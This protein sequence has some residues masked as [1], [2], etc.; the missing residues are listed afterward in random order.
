MSKKNRNAKKQQAEARSERMKNLTMVTVI[1]LFLGL[2]IFALVQMFVGSNEEP[3]AAQ[4]SE[5][6]FE[7]EGQPVL[8]DPDAP[9][10]IVEFG[11]FKC[12]ACKQFKDQI[13]PQ[14]KKDY[15]DQGKVAFYFVNNPFIGE[16]SMTAAIAAES[17]YQQDPDSYWPYF[18]AL[19]DNQ[20]NEQQ[21]WATPELLVKLAKEETP[22]VDADQVKK[23]IENET[24]KEQVE[25][26]RQIVGKAGV[27]SV[28]TLFVN[29]RKVEPQE[30]F[31]YNN[32]K[33]IIDQAIEEAQ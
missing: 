19:Y 27:T 24:Y 9:V 15:I 1:V 2:G 6:I 16:D 14:L 22:E 20:G 7:Y 32:L 26:D 18:E 25:K 28:P 31:Q 13:Y 11:D 12:P 10:K 5:K 3:E 21:V 30:A 33:N 4:V 23:D 17:V 29:G 8:G